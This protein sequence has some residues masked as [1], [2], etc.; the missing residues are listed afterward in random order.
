MTDLQRLKEKLISLR[1]KTM[2]QEL[3]TILENANKKNTDFLSILDRLAD[4]EAEHRRQNAIKLRFQ[5]SKLN[6]KTTI[7]QFDFNHHKSRKEQKTQILNLFNLEFVT[8]HKDVILIGNPG[9]GKTFLAKSIA[10]AA[11]NANVKVLF[12]TA[13]D[14]INHLIAA[15]ADHSLLKKLH[16]YQ[17]PALLVCDELGYLSLGQQ[18]SHLFFQVISARHQIKSTLLTT[19][20]PFAE[21]GNV[22]DS[23]T[24]ATA[25][26][27]R[28]VHNS[29]VLIMRGTSYRRKQK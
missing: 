13:I 5:Q 17:S 12:T 23:T 7:D 27:D 25:I 26:A 3:D 14:M 22:F 20:L 29:E 10:Y 8:E 9:T 28:L 24:V 6:E 2:A 11:C 1:L 15:E 18:G 19:N 16:Y 4:V 21:W